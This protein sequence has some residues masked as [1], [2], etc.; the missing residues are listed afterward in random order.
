[1]TEVICTSNKSGGYSLT[2]K[3]IFVKTLK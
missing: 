2:I 3:N 1:M